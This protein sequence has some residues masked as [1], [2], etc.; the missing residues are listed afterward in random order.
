[1][2]FGTYNQPFN[3]TANSGR[4]DLQSAIEAQTDFL[5]QSLPSTP[6]TAQP[7]LIPQQQVDQSQQGAGM[8]NMSQPQNQYVSG[9]SGGG[10]FFGAGPGGKST[11]NFNGL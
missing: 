5:K 11:S 10:Q 8:L 2:S 4:G 1:M 7:S 9:K 6:Q 3:P